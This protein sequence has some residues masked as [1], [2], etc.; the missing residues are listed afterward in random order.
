MKMIVGFKLQLK[1]TILSYETNF[2]KKKN[3]KI[4]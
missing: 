1:K 3:K 2:K 4:K